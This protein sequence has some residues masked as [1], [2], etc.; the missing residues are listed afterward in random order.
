M[1]ALRVS[2]IIAEFS[3]LEPPPLQFWTRRRPTETRPLTGGRFF[4]TTK[5]HSER[6]VLM[7]AFSAGKRLLCLFKAI[8]L[9]STMVFESS[10]SKLPPFGGTC[11]WN[12]CPTEPP[13]KQ[14]Y[15]D[16]KAFSRGSKVITM[17]NHHHLNHHHLRGRRF[18]DH[19]LPSASSP[20]K[21]KK[22]SL[23]LVMMISESPQFCHHFQ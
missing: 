18:L 8:F 3:A 21:S 9:L 19:F 17:V 11:F 1:G 4:A 2:D 23:V 14:I 15:E 13:N 22:I 5:F 6:T 7:R 16:F 12:F 20:G 10:P